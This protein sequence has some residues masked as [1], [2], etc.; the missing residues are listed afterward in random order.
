MGGYTQNFGNS[1]LKLLGAP[2]T[3]ENQRAL[4]AW[5]LAEGGNATN[6]PFNSGETISGATQF[7]PD[8]LNYPDMQ[9]GLA[10]TFRNLQNPRYTKLVAALKRG[11]SAISVAQEIASSPWGTGGGALQVLNADGSGLPAAP[12]GEILNKS[13][14]ATD[15]GNVTASGPTPTPTDTGSQ[16]WFQSIIGAVD[17]LTGLTD[18][19]NKFLWI[20]LP[21]SWIRIQ[22]GIAGFVLLVIAIIL[23][24]KDSSN[25]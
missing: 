3:A 21:S 2:I 6:N 24:A 15:T 5:G 7:N 10:A 4:T 16:N 22:A 9:S 12:L 19:L 13:V 11:N 23:F 14:P 1:L 18:F 25:A 20:F 8:V 17:P